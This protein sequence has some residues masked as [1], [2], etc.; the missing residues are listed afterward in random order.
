[1]SDETNDVRL[2]RLE[3]QLKGVRA[4]VDDIRADQKSQNSKLG[5]LLEYHQQ[6]KGKQELMK[7]FMAIGGSSGFL[8]LLAL[9]WSK[10]HS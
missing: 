7:V 9:L 5:L 2:A 1:M 6:R 8:S 10:L 4:N 3:E